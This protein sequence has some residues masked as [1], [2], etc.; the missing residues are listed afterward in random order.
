MGGCVRKILTESE[1]K[2][3]RHGLVTMS[4][5]TVDQMIKDG[6][7]EHTVLDNGYMVS[8][9]LDVKR[10][11]SRIFHLSISNT[12]GTTDTEIAKSMAKDIIGED[13]QMV[14]PQKFKNIIHFTKVE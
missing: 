5:G 8:L 9:S 10:E 7:I 3:I 1:V 6:G 13:A 11:N 14:C 4:H 12:K 2:K